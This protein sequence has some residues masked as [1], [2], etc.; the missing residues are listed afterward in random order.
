MLYEVITRVDLVL[1]TGG[2]GPTKDDITKKCLC[3]YFECS[4][5]S[6]EQTL[7][8][9]IDRFAKRNI[10]VNQLNRDQA[11]VP[12]ACTVLPNKNGTAPGMW[13][14]KKDTIFVSM[15]GVPYEMMGIM[16]EE[17]LPRLRKTG[18]VKSIYHQT[19]LVYGIGEST[20]AEILEAW[21][22]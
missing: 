12:D 7:Q 10:P 2:L 1:I 8:A 5:H 6:D 20:L 16:E 13:F 15:P 22:V 17:V 19:A 18:K 3:E 9:V 11:L 21:V 14:E 4:M